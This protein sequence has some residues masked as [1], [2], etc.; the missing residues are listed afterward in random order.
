MDSII[1]P[2]YPEPEDEPEEYADYLRR[3]VVAMARRY[4]VEHGHDDLKAKE[5]YAGLCLSYSLVLNRV[6]GS[7]IE[8]SHA[9]L[10]DIAQI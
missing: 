1:E 3:K 4:F 10:E 8:R 9:T 6:T 7:G 5:S 2:S